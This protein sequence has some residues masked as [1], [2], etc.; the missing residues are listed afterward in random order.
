MLL[1]SL[2]SNPYALRC[3]QK[4]EPGS[5]RVQPSVLPTPPCH[6]LQITLLLKLSTKKNCPFLAKT[7]IGQALK[8]ALRAVC[9]GL[10]RE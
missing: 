3:G 2:V 8:A 5:A 6:I 10:S 9:R 7:P 4:S 1:G